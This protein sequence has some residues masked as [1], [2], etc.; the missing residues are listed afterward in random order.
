MER[1]SQGIL[2]FICRNMTVDDET[3]EIYKYG[4]EITLSSIINL[5]LIIISSLLLGDLLGGLIF[6]LLFIL[7]RSYTGGYHAETYLRCNTAFVITFIIT[8]I[9][10]RLMN[11][12]KLDII[13]IS[14]LLILSYIPIL[15]L[16]PVKNRHKVLSEE[17]RKRSRIISAV[18]YFGSLVIAVL[19]CLNNIWYG[20]LLSTTDI[21]VSVL[22]LVEVYMQKKGYHP[23]E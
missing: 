22:I 3:A 11:S 1:M 2:D 19:L 4:I 9:S 12:V 20:Y 5:L 13:F 7:L 17:K 23:T 21:S 16:S 6:M 14:A 15:I 8:F 10:A 18:V